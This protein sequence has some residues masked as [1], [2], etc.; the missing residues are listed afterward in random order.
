MSIYEKTSIIGLRLTQ[1][2]QGA[3]S[4]LSDEDLKKCRSIREIVDMELEKKVIP[5]MIERSMPNQ[6]KTI[7]DL[8][9]L[10]I[11]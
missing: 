11:I 6:P 3:P 7:W 4:T 2:S 1:L 9:N 10:I 5:F 8:D